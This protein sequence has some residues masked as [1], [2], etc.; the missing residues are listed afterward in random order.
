MIM[1]IP[2]FA[3]IKIFMRNAKYI[4]SGLS[5][6]KNVCNCEKKTCNHRA[7]EMDFKVEGPWNTENYF[8][9]PW[10]FDKKNLDALDA[11]E[12]LKQ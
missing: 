1:S 11:Q 12:W 6:T 7:G 8:R 4:Q 9:S 5:I 3:S 2:S 10:L